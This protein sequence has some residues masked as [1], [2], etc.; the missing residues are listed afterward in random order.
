MRSLPVLLGPHLEDTTGSRMTFAPLIDRRTND[1]AVRVTDMIVCDLDLEVATVES[2]G[3]A[4]ELSPEGDGKIGLNGRMTDCAAG[5]G[6]G[7]V[8]SNS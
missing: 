7:P 4:T 6:F 5:H 3:L 8:T 2:T 1:H